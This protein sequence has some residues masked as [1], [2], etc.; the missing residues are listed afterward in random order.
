M[1]VALMGASGA[2]GS[3]LAAELSRRGH[4]VTAI[5][6]H[7]DKIA[8]SP[9][10]TAKK[11]DVFD[12]AGLAQ[13]LKGHDAVV[14]AVRFSASDPKL[15]IEAVKQSGVRRY[16]VVGGAASLE[17]APGA[18]LIDTPQFPA[19]YKAEA[20]KGGEFLD[21]L[22][23]DKDLDWT[24]LSPSAAIAPGERT[25]K[26]RLGKDQLLTTD[27]GSSISWEDYAIAAVDELEKPAHIRERFTVGY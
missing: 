3:R 1:K 8:K 20:A 27:K 14:S 25:G 11:G 9:G 10:V 7:P 18:K 13:L 4:E 22:R 17:V 5:A 6:R 21:L 15:L 26:F 2:G 24:F 23:K 19:A 12:K 16:F